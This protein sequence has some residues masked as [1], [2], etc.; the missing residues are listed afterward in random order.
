MHAR[1]PCSVSDL[2]VRTMLAPEEA[3]LLIL[4]NF[5]QHVIE[6]SRCTLEGGGDVLA[7]VAADDGAHVRHGGAHDGLQERQ[8]VQQLRVVGLQLP[9]R[10]LRKRGRRVQ[11]FDISTMRAVALQHDICDAGSSFAARQQPALHG[12]T[13]ASLQTWESSSNSAKSV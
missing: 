3:A 2:M 7:L 4:S 13:A 9:R 5:Y 12:A 11:S 1:K 8:Q 10:Q 6:R